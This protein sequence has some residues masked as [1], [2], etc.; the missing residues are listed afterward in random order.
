VCAKLDIFFVLQ[1]CIFI[2]V[3]CA[4][5]ASISPPLFIESQESEQL[6]IYVLEVSI[7]SFCF[8]DLQLDFD[9]SHSAI[10]LYICFSFY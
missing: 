8:H 5:K 4:Q 2:Y 6:C 7:L 1:N 3:N 9:T 10:F